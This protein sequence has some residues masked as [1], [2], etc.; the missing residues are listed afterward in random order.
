MYGLICPA[1]P[2][3]PS[4][5]GEIR[6]PARPTIRKRRRRPRTARGAPERRCTSPEVPGLVRALGGPVRGDS[7]NGR[8]RRESR[9]DGAWRVNHKIPF[10]PSQKIRILRKNRQHFETFQYLQALSRESVTL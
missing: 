1:P 9:K 8:R 2:I 6:P 10:S 5:G 7:R 4:P 3:L